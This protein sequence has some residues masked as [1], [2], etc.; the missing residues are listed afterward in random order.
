MTRQ[1]FHNWSDHPLAVSIAMTSAILTIAGFFLTCANGSRQQIT[2]APAVPATVKGDSDQKLSLLRIDI[3]CTEL[4][5]DDGTWNYFCDIANR[6]DETIWWKNRFQFKGAGLSWR[7][8]G[9]GQDQSLEDLVSPCIAKAQYGG[10]ILSDDGAVRF[11][12]LSREEV[13]SF[14]LECKNRPFTCIV[15]GRAP[16]VTIN[17]AVWVTIDK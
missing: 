6:S 5:L 1:P 14:S 13:A 8:I 2:S 3:K 4:G 7:C 16:E 9:Q 10:L 15:G 11:D 17:Q 12:F